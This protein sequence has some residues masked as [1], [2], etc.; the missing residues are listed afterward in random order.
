MTDLRASGHASGKKKILVFCDSYL[1]GINGGGGVWTI[2]NLVDRFCDS[3]DFFIVTRNHDGRGDRRPYTTVSAGDWN[4]IGNASVFYLSDE[5]VTQAMLAEL[6]NGVRPGS[7]FLN[8]TMSDP[9]VKFLMARR[10]GLVAD[11]PVIVASTGEFSPGALRSKPLKKKA[12]LSAAR[13]TGLFN[14]VIWKASTETEA[15]EIRRAI[16]VDADIMIASD[17]TPNDVLADYS[18]AMKPPKR[19]G[20]ARLIFYSRIEQKKNLKYLLEVL[21][22]VGAGSIT[23]DIVGT[24]EDQKYWRECELLIA[25]LPAN[26]NAQ[27][28]GGVTYDAG[29][30]HLLSSH[31]FLL[32]TLGENFGYVLIESLAAGTPVIT[33]DRVVWD[34]L[35][36][37]HVGRRIA[38][39]NKDEWRREIECS[40]EMDGPEYR[41]MSD[42]ARNYALEWLA[43][44]EPELANAA[45]L[46]RATGGGE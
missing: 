25:G 36:K 32:P 13:T 8:S 4:T 22:D 15:W 19:K 39:K 37:K 3:Y 7:V 38:L 5:D 40:I 10:R 11:I 1:P 26:I 28:A 27:V 29:L 35:E 20:E 23:L 43:R 2:V 6:A 14:N 9:C 33:S 18:P 31:F 46:E 45:V 44:R 30:K 17:L 12:Y 34:D 16:G 24:H 21:G 42:A 41:A